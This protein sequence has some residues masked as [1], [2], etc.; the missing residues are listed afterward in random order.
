[1]PE[2]DE[3]LG[4]HVHMRRSQFIMVAIASIALPTCNACQQ[5][6]SLVTPRSKMT[7]V[8]PISDYSVKDMVMQIDSS[9]VGNMAA[10]TYELGEYVS[11]IDLTTGHVKANLGTAEK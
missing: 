4:A 2:E 1:M 10:V 6:P 11:I 5:Q 8:T 9:Q 7:R 3:G